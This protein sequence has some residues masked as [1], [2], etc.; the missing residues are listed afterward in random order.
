MSDLLN[1]CN[2]RLDSAEDFEHMISA[3]SATLLKL[4]FLQIGFIPS[5]ARQEKIT[6]HESNWRLDTYRTVIPAQK[7]SQRAS[8][9]WSKQQ[10]QI[11]FRAQMDLKHEY[12]MSGSS[13]SY[14]DWCKQHDQDNN[15]VEHKV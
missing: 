10:R 8:L 2:E 11:G 7:P 14:E 1:R 12:K 4:N 6:L 13:L 5:H 15:D 3:F 9:F